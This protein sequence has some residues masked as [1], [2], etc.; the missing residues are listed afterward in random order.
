MAVGIRSHKERTIKI[1]LDLGGREEHTLD[2]EEDDIIP[3]VWPLKYTPEFWNV[4]LPVR[5]HYTSVMSAGNDSSASDT[6]IACH[7]R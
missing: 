5:R 2:I 7:R 1:I 6:H 4:S 3:K